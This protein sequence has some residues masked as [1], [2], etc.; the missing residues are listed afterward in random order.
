MKNDDV[1][2]IQR[3]LAGDENAFSTLVRKYEKPVH[4]FVWR[5]IG[6]FHI[7]EEITQDAFLQAYKELATLKK[8]NRFARWLSVIATRGCIAWLRKKRLSTQSLED[9]THAQL[10]KAT[11]SGYVIQENERT[12]AETQREVVQKLLAKLREKE[13]IVITL[14][15]FGEMT[16][17]EISEFLGTSVGTIKSRL[18][19]A[20][21]RL[22]REEPM[23]REA[24]SGFQ[25]AQNFTE[26]V[27]HEVSRI[28]PTPSTGG[29][30]SSV[31][32]IIGASAVAAVFLILGIGYH[33]SNRFGLPSS[34][35]GD[36]ATKALKTGKVVFSSSRD[37]NWDIWTMN[38]DG[39][40]P[41]NLTQDTAVDI[42][43]AW[44][45]T[46]EQILF[47]SFREE[48]KEPSLYLMDA[49]GNHIRKVLDNWY[50]RSSA[51]WAP[52]GKRI[53]SVRDGV[54]YIITLDDKSAVP[55]AQT[56]FESVGD[57]DWSPDGKEIAF[58]Y[59]KRKQGY[60]LRLL[61]VRTLK[62]KVVLAQL[63]R[64]PVKSDPSWS[65]DGEQIAFVL[66]KFR[67]MLNQEDAFAWQDEETIYTIN[68]DGSNL[69][70]LVSEKG[71]DALHPTWSPDGHEIIYQ[72]GIH[73]PE[74]G[75]IR[76]L[77]K[78]DVNRRRKTQL[79]HKGSNSG[80][81]WFAPPALP[82]EP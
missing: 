7:A 27:M 63:E 20:Q 70:Q 16:H 30:Q 65:P 55:V 38:P 9:T 31:P 76:Q 43:A 8:P 57:P 68:H 50:S 81:D 33:Y 54:L 32:W 1:E 67:S 35:E 77:F 48:G 15:Y 42:H 69:R 2:L 60:E 52:D 45:P 44:S 53:A 3:V 71:P 18:R 66:H 36:I 37:G 5:K 79:T 46:G 78:I 62:Q 41:V 64:Y 10:E 28:T 23:V 4:A 82:D 75:D 74:V 49:D 73:L 72:Q 47:T 29:S 56:G 40:D 13:R 34:S 61:D 17:E 19:R 51:T 25:I 11:Y 22:K 14:H 12:T 59:Y 58:I 39:S 24:L 6:D 21:Q 26:K 80:A